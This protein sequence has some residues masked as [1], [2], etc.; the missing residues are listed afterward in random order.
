MENKK[1]IL[2]FQIFSMIFASILGVVL[3]FIYEW[4]NNNYIIA[5]FSAVNESTWEHLKLLFFPMLLT[6]IIGYYYIGKNIMNFLCAKTIG[7]FVAIVF[8]VIFFY[9]SSGVIGMNISFLNITSF[10]IAVVLGEWVAYKIMLSDF[11]CNN[12]TATIVLMVL[13]ISF[14]IFTFFTPQIGLFRDPL[15]KKYGISLLN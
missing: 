5:M 1:A 4:S 10:F 15:T 2:R 11:K 13:I 3:H 9:T 8:T 6:I 14:V 7:I 12:S